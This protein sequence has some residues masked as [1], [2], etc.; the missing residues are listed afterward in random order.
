MFQILFDKI[1]RIENI[2]SSI[3]ETWIALNITGIYQT[4]HNNSYFVE[5]YEE[6]SNIGVTLSMFIDND[7]VNWDTIDEDL[8]DGAEWRINIDKTSLYEGTNVINNFFFHK[9][10]FLAWILGS[11]PVSSTYPLNNRK[12]KIE[13]YRLET[14]FGGPNI[15]VGP[16][17]CN[18]PEYD[19]S[20]YEERHILSL[21]RFFTSQSLS[22][23][24]SNHI[25]T[26]GEV[27]EYSK[28]FY[29]NAVQCMA[30]SLCDE[31]Y[32]E[33]VILRGVRRIEQTRSWI[34]S[35][36]LDLKNY[37]DTLLKTICWV[38][39]ADSRF[40]LRH[41]LLMDRITLD[42]PVNGSITDGLAKIIKDALEQAVERYHFAIYERG[43]QYQKELRDLL[44]DIRVLSDSYSSKVRSV[45][46][47]LSRDVLAGLL[48]VGVTLFSKYSEM[49]RSSNEGILAFVF[50]AYGVYYICSILIQT[51]VDWIDLSDSEHEFDH[52]KNSAREYLTADEFQKHKK[53][54]IGKRKAKTIWQ[55]VG[56]GILYIGLSVFC[57]YASGIWSNITDDDKV[58]NNKS[59]I[60]AI[61]QEMDSTLIKR[62]E[63]SNDTTTRIKN[64]TQHTA[65]CRKQK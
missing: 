35:E 60:E 36:T 8:V 46:S 38:Y 24:P 10:K 44:K 37:H 4:I 52:W 54:T 7:R 47:N 13:V 12:C 61:S 43:T 25:L 26:F 39:D 33:K 28:P 5:L 22:I 50:K 6:A 16:S 45:I 49:T 58:Q 64:T 42:I 18:F 29:K 2:S 21:I 40:E 62:T 15:V 31:I 51:V 48:T 30:L 63:E 27:N 3:D 19:I 56:V 1:S 20:S 32:D 14:S 65:H 57:F 23:Y 9:E 53:D 55:Y 34:D 59:D 41:K 11:N 17:D